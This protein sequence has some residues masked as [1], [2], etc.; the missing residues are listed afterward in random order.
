MGSAAETVKKATDLTNELLESNADNLRTANAEVRKQMERGVFD[1]ES[2]RKAN[3]QLIETIN[4][5]L[6]IAEEGK[7]KRAEASKELVQMESELRTALVSAKAR[8]ENPVSEIAEEATK[9]IDS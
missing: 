6:K 8:A 9:A 1:I 4:D 7:A 5:S 3:N 2:V